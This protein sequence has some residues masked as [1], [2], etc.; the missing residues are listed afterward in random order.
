MRNE[1]YQ[2]ET[3]KPMKAKEGGRPAGTYGCG[4]FKS[5]AFDQA[6]G[7]QG[8]AG[9]MSDMKKIHAQHNSSY[10]DDHSATKG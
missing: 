1:H 5:E 3:D 8:K 6:W 9:Y 10:M 4:D 7:Q 2:H